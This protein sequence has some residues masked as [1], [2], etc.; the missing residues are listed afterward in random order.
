ML[1]GS[2]RIRPGMRTRDST[3]SK[4]PVTI[5]R[6]EDVQFKEKHRKFEI[7]DW[8]AEQVKIQ[9]NITR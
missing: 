4:R 7:L 9:N 2:V 6:G 5:P 8:K 1:K 3:D